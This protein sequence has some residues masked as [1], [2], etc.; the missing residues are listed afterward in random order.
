MI[1]YTSPRLYKSNHMIA[2]DL[3]TRGWSTGGFFFFFF[4][5]H[6]LFW[7]VVVVVMIM[8]V[9]MR[10]ARKTAE[11]GGWLFHPNG[12]HGDPYLQSLFQPDP[13]IYP[14]HTS[15]SECP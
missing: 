8:G 12:P 14:N 15:A 13:I 5:L 1:N 3:G 9:A 7:G 2:A 11:L 4:F 10:L 6:L